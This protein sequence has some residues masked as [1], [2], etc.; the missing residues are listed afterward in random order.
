MISTKPLPLSHALS[1]TFLPHPSPTYSTVY[2]E[3]H[4][5]R[6]RQG[7]L[8]K[9]SPQKGH[10]IPNSP[11]QTKLST[12]YPVIFFSVYNFF[13]L[14]QIDCFSKT[15]DSDQF[16]SKTFFWFRSILLQNSFDPDQF[17]PICFREWS[18]SASTSAGCGNG[19]VGKLS[20]Q[21]AVGFIFWTNNLSKI[22]MY[23]LHNIGH[24]HMALS[25]RGSKGCWKT[26]EFWDLCLQEENLQ[27][28]PPLGSCI[29]QALNVVKLFPTF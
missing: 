10:I 25:A 6:R 29:E 24:T 26:I 19:H 9:F 16:I 14:C 22:W 18:R 8:K 21:V 1:S 28:N 2:T 3:G 4:I 15:L 23:N 11:T 13:F 27:Q 12:I 17:F 5:S 7:D 20:I